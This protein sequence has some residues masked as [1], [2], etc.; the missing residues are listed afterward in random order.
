MRHTNRSEPSAAGLLVRQ[1]PC[2]P[3]AENHSQN[4]VR[5]RSSATDH[6]KRNGEKRRHTGG[7]AQEERGLGIGHFW[8]QGEPASPGPHVVGAH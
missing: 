1:I 6:G 2:Y 3:N 4:G 7:G 8:A 5:A